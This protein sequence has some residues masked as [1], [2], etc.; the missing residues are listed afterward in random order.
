MGGQVGTYTQAVGYL[1]GTPFG[2]PTPLVALKNKKSKCQKWPL[3]RPFW[4][5]DV[6]FFENRH[7]AIRGLLG[8]LRVGLDISLYPP[9]P[10]YSLMTVGIEMG[11]SYHHCI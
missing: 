3:Q 10:G 6:L 7:E 8:W 1:L 11:G 5:L 4:D 2:S 9:T